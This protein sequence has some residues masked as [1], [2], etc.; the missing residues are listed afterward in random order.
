[1]NIQEFIT[2]FK[3]VKQMGEN[4]YMAL[5]PAHND[6]NPSLSIGLSENKKQILLHQT[7]L[8]EA[9]FEVTDGWTNG[10]DG[11][12]IFEVTHYNTPV[13]KNETYTGMFS[14]FYSPQNAAQCLT[15]VYSPKRNQPRR[16]YTQDWVREQ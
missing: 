14:V 1:M 11:F 10:T 15:K 12:T 5:C 7:S 9:T 4:Q 6:K 8:S 2:H 13:I 3:E 16:W